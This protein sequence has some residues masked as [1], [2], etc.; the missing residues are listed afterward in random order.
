M[1]FY[2]SLT[3]IIVLI[4]LL[5]QVYNS[6][7]SGDFSNSL[8]TESS[9]ADKTVMIIVPHQDD[10]IN[11]AG[12]TIKNLTD[13]HIHVI[14]VFATT[15]DYHDSGIDR[16][17]EALAASQI[18]GVPEEDIVFLGYCNMP[19]VNETQ[20]FYNADEDLIITSDQ[21]LQET[22]ALP[23]KPEFCFN[24]TNKH[25][26]YTKKKSTYRYTRSNNVL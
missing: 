21:G 23:E 22:Y 19:M 8:W 13:N 26:K 15:S 4:F 11:L 6:A 7:Y 25:K 2:L 14:V 12:A 18:L 9:L 24:T 16:L 17:H 10:E 1:T 5:Y 3:I 20:H